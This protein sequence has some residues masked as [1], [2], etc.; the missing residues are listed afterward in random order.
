LIYYFVGPTF[1]F[2]IIKSK[3]RPNK[4]APKNA[5]FE[6]RI[7][8]ESGIFEKIPNQSLTLSNGGYDV[9]TSLPFSLNRH[10]ASHS[11]HVSAQEVETK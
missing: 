7:E 3:I 4:L 11:G 6:W 8:R 2:K 9:R 10:L 5:N 1:P